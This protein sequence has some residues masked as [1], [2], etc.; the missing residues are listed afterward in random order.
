[1]RT[2]LLL[3]GS[4]IGALVVGVLAFDFFLLEEAKVA[5]LYT[6]TAG[7]EVLETQLW[8]VDSNDLGVGDNGNL[9]LRADL[10][11]VAWLRRLR[12]VPEVELAQGERVRP[13]RAKIEEDP[14]LAAHLDGAMARK[15]GAADAIL[16]VL[17]RRGR[18]V[19]VR[20]EP[21]ASRKIAKPGPDNG[22]APH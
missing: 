8:V 20:L 6:R 10:A 18:S 7:G 13:F 4:A 12:E 21:D 5:T 17:F 19:A 15:Y 14:T 16:G 9:W 11:G 1:V 2:A 3:I 22:P